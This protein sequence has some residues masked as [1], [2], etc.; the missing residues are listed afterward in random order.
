MRKR[1]VSRVRTTEG[2][3]LLYAL[4]RGKRKFGVQITLREEDKETVDS[5][6]DLFRRR[7]M[8]VR[9]LRVL[10]KEQVYPVHLKEIA[11]QFEYN[12]L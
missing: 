11:D 8:A 12:L 4:L 5:Y 10:S 6:E 7:S 1:T 2:D 9:F 3:V